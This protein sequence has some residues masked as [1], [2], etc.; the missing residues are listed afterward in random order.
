MDGSKEHDGDE[1]S[2]MNGQVLV[3]SGPGI[4]EVS[5]QNSVMTG[6]EDTE[7]SDSGKGGQKFCKKCNALQSGADHVCTSDSGVVITGEE[8]GKGEDE[9]RD[10]DKEPGMFDG[11]FSD[12]DDSE[13]ASEG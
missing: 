12:T 8:P 5:Q 7:G 13:E 6:N 9:L 11:V 10:E 1:T 4:T 2:N 3:G